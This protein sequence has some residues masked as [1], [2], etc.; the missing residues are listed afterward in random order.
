M[1]KKLLILGGVLTAA[2]TAAVVFFVYWKR[3][4][5]LAVATKELTEN[6]LKRVA[7]QEDNMA[8]YTDI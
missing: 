8:D 4:L 2:A 1:F 7:R 6:V 5:A 3:I